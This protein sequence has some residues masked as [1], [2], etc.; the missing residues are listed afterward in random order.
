[1]IFAIIPARGGSQRIKKKK[2]KEI[3]FKTHSILDYKSIKTK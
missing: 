2:Y 3:L 1:M